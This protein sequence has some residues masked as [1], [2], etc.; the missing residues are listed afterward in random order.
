MTMFRWTLLLLAGL[1]LMPDALA[2]DARDPDPLF[3]NTE[4][5]EASISAP[6]STLLKERPEVEE[7]AGTLQFTDAL[8]EVVELDLQIRTRGRFRRD[9]DVCRFPPLRLNLKKSQTKDTLF[10]KQDKLSP[11]L[12]ESFRLPV[13]G[14]NV[15]REISL[16]IIMVI[17]V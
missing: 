9:L 8:G 11:C 6:M 17:H 15:G 16:G 3:Q 14:H 4:I 13:A 12:C 2:K 7:L 1:P 10:H 5:L